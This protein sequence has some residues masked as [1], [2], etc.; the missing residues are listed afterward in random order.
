MN[1]YSKNQ[2]C[3][4]VNHNVLVHHVFISNLLGEGDTPS[5]QR[6]LEVSGKYFYKL[7]YDSSQFWVI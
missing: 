2:G 7:L 6:F 3:I 5:F 1:Q 4:D